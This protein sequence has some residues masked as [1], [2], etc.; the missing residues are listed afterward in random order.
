MEG[1][2]LCV[3]EEVRRS[4]DLCCIRGPSGFPGCEILA[5]ALWAV[6]PP[7]VSPLG[8]AA[9]G[10]E[11]RC[12]LSRTPDS[13]VAEPSFL[14]GR[15]ALWNPAVS[16]SH[17]KFPHPA[18]PSEPARACC[19]RRGSRAS[20]EKRSSLVSDGKDTQHWERAACPVSCPQARPLHTSLQVTNVAPA[21]GWLRQGKRPGG[22]GLTSFCPH[23]LRS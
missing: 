16:F 2:Q 22:G 14:H 12:L 5:R 23:P 21:D 1:G 4:G 6:L 3:Q 19:R 17:L 13:C 8:L 10:A 15:A 7:W 18:W 20:L 11:A 9:V